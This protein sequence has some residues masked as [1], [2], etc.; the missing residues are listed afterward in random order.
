MSFGGI[1]A[2]GEIHTTTDNDQ[3]RRVISIRIAWS[4][5]AI[6]NVL[7]LGAYL[8]IWLYWWFVLSSEYVPVMM[9]HT[10]FARWWDSVCYVAGSWGRAMGRTWQLWIIPLPLEWV[11][12]LWLLVWHNLRP[13]LHNDGW[14]PP[15]SQMA[16]LESGA[17][18][19]DNFDSRSKLRVSSPAL[20]PPTYHAEG[21]LEGERHSIYTQFP[22]TDPESWHAFCKAVRGGANFSGS[23]YER[24]AGPGKRPDFE[25]VLDRWVSQD[26]Q[27]A[28]VDPASIGP[29]KTPELTRTGRLMIK[30]FA[31]TP[32][33]AM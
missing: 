7:T 15:W 31:T 14:P 1:G 32:P 17:L 9:R 16:P 8:V 29:R 25:K 30:L 21:R 4:M 18:T 23:E 3:T 33:V 20:S 13:K 27:K 6:L 5:C 24:H 28:L 10:A 12:P 22:I 26:P 19:W 2:R 11:W